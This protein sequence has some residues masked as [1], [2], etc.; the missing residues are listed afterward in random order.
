MVGVEDRKYQMRQFN[1]LASHSASGAH[2]RTITVKVNFYFDYVNVG[3][4]AVEVFSVGFYPEQ[5][6]TWFPFQMQLKWS[7]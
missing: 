5:M 7:S 6:F 3:F 2:Y 4:P 1:P